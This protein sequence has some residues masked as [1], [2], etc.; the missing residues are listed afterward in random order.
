MN[1]NDNMVQNPKTEVKETIEMNDKDYMNSVLEVEKNMSNNYSIA[2][3]EASNESLYQE[4]LEMFLNIQN[5]QR[6][7]YELMFR[8]GW[9]PIEEADSNKVDQKHQ[10]LLQEKNQLFQG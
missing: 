4:Y 6:E 3:N 9:Y 5:Q 1:N 8:M 7:L 2:M 10:K